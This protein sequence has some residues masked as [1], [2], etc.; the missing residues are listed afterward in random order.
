LQPFRNRGW[1]SGQASG[2]WFWERVICGVGSRLTPFVFVGESAEWARADLARLL[3]SQ[4]NQIYAVIDDSPFE[5][6][7]FSLDYQRQGQNTTAVDPILRLNADRNTYLLI[8]L[9]AKS[10]YQLT[11]SPGARR[12][13]E[14]HEYNNWESVLLY[15]A[16]WLTL[17]ERELAEAARRDGGSTEVAPEWALKELPTEY[18][19]IVDQ[20]AALKETE[21][22]LRHMSGL[23]WETGEALN[24][25]VRKAFKEIGFPAEATQPGATYDVTVPLSSGR[26]L[27]E[28]TGIEGQ[29]NKASKKISQVV[30]VIQK[31]LQAGDR[32]CVGI[33]AHRKVAPAE[34]ENLELLTPDASGLL[35]RLD[36]V[37]FTTS[38]LFAIWK[39]SRTDPDAARQH[40]SSIYK[41]PAGLFRVR[42]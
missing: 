11:R 1:L 18:Q 36:A 38:D 31:E 14:T 42:I 41:A 4:E 17:V 20:I 23:W 39:L 26:L 40:V 19:Q 25:L 3:P 28:V 8:A 34:R 2:C 32:V 9:R 35:T 33:N 27:V 15:I 6:S 10:T 5:R 12:L 21:R 7:A 13:A 29:V 30:A 22:R 16:E 37:V 24:R